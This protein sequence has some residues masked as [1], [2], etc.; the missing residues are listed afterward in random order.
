MHKIS[1]SDKKLIAKNTWELIFQ[2]LE[3]GTL[4]IEAGQYMRLVI[5]EIVGG[6]RENSR[7]F[8]AILSSLMFRDLD[9][10]HF[11]VVFRES[12]SA[13]KQY[14]INAPIGAQMT[15]YGP[16][17][18]FVLPPCLEVEPLNMGWVAGGVGIAPFLSMARYATEEKLPH[19]I[20]LFYAN[21]DKESS[22]YLPELA[23]LE[24]QNPNFSVRLKFGA[25]DGEFLSVGDC[26]AF[27]FVYIAGPMGMVSEAKKILAEI[28]V[29]SEKIKCEI[30]G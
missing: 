18:E 20:T 15:A 30:F 1:L 10:K 27:D 16:F 25:M 28:G 26:P 4:N 14:L 6:A 3:T 7:I 23:E 17:G 8:S 2:C 29:G 9:S 24:R 5:P 22:T 21:M 11:G 19:R 12:P 13:F